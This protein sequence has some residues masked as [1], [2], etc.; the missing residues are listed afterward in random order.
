MEG[1]GLDFGGFGKEYAADQVSSLLMDLS[2]ENFLVDFGG[3]IFAAGYA[4][5]ECSWKVGI[6]MPDGNQNPA[7]IVNL[8]NRGLATLGTTENSLTLMVGDMVI[9]LIIAL[10]TPPF[11]LNL[12]HL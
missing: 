1:M 9:P 5:E 4:D 10:D 6:E 3:D 2:C 7:F 11:I 8:T 12:V